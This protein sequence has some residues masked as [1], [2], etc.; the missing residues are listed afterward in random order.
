MS[1]HFTKNN[2]DMLD[3]AARCIRLRQYL[4]ALVMIYTHIDTLARAGSTKQKG[5]VRQNFEEWV[6]RW[7]LPEMA[8]D[9]PERYL[10]HRVW[11]RLSRFL[12]F[13]FKPAEH[14]WTLHRRGLQPIKG[15][16]LTTWPCA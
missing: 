4:P 13:R 3:A 10:R 12:S 11:C 15:L 2:T 14:G 5:T 16:Y 6:N 7:L 9:A 1:P 8:A